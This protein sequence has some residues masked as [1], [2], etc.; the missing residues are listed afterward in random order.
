MNSRTSLAFAQ[1]HIPGLKFLRPVLLTCAGLLLLA[2]PGSADD[3][4][5]F[6]GPRYDGVSLETGWTA[7][8]PVSGPVVAWEKNVGV[9]ASS[10]VV[11]GNRVLTMGNRRD[12]DEDVV[13]TGIYQLD[14]FAADSK[15]NI[16]V[17]NFQTENNHIFKFNPDGTFNRSFGHHGQGPGELSRPIAIICT[18]AEELLVSDPDNT[19]LVYLSPEGELPRGG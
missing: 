5:F 10:F 12:E 6:R 17:L 7:Q 11:V 18:D 14:T 1:H 16:Y 4:P 3:W 2:T 19:K 9:G 13:Q 15:G 8:W